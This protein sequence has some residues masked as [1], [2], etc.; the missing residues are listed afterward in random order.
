[1]YVK[2]E[3]TPGAKRDSVRETGEHRFAISVREKA[4]RGM[5]NERVRELLAEHFNVPVKAVRIVNGHRHPRK[6]FSI[7]DDYK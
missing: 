3:V 4:K 5:A 1:M 6:L 7:E 2:V